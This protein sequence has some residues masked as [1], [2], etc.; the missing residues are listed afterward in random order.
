MLEFDPVFFPVLLVNFLVLIIALHFILFKPLIAVF[1]ERE[2]ATDG[3][4]KMAEELLMKKDEAV[5]KLQKELSEARDRAKELYSSLKEEGQAKQKELLGTAHDEAMKVLEEA[6]AKLAAEAETARKALK[7]EA[8]R[9]AEEIV[10]KLV[11]V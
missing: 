9:Y 3:S 10:N 4:R 5:K 8:D 6:R 7:E 1:R 2:Q 11:K